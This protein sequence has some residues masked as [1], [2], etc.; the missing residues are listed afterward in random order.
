MSQVILLTQEG[1]DK[2]VAEYDELV[3]VKRKEVAERIK[4]AI[5]YGDISENSEYDSA[6]NEQAELEDRIMKLEN[7]MRNAKIIDHS[8]ISDDRVNVGL[9]VKIKDKASGEVIDFTIVGSTEADPFEGKISNESEVGK[10]LIGKQV[11]DV[12]EVNVPDGTVS[13]EVMRIYK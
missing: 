12:A 8:E 6:K 4:E 11:G 7:M 2:I 9:N 3:T 10:Q 1:H 13:Y 5:S